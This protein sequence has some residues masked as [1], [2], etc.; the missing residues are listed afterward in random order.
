M[1]GNNYLDLAKVRVVA[2]LHLVS[3]SSESSVSMEQSLLF[4][5]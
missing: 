3:R 5:L 2:F 1:K 4:I